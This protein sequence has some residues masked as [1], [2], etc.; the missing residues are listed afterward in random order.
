M[1]QASNMPG[2]NVVVPGN[3]AIATV[4]GQRNLCKDA[5]SITATS[6]TIAA[7]I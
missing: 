4:R 3:I 1:G 6:N 2:Q 7:L 5:R